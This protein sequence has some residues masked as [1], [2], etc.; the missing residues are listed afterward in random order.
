MEKN[1]FLSSDGKSK[2]VYYISEPVIATKGVVQICHGMCE[3][4]ERYSEFI[5][6]MNDSG[7]IVYGHDHLG[8]GNTGKENNSF[9]FFGE[10]NG[11]RY[12]V[13]DVKRMTDIIRRD[14][15]EKKLFLLGHSM[16]SFILRNYLTWY[17]DELDG[18]IIMG[19]SGGVPKNA[20]IIATDL[21]TQLKGSTTP[22]NTGTK[23]LYDTFNRRIEHKIS[24]SDWITRDIEKISM[25]QSDEL[26]NFNFTAK[27]YSDM[28]RLLVNVS[29]PDWAES[30]R[31]D[32]P[33]LLISGAMDPVGDY[34]KGVIK[35]YQRLKS[36]GI[37]DLSLRIFKDDRHEL[38]NEINRAEIYDFLLGWID[39]KYAKAT[40]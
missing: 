5:R 20:A 27:G 39:K 21:L 12:L 15:P 2:I 13:R 22:L 17:G 4:I 36:C 35:V 7:Y 8:H 6:F 11:W 32:L 29:E 23:L 1:S 10:K 33:I 30:V 19:T 28:V 9:G 25:Y 16:G 31:H 37:S 40:R 18:A 34:G 3:H 14:Y 38:I 24:D 26:G